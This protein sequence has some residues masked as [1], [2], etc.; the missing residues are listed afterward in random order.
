MKRRVSTNL[1]SKMK[2]LIITVPTGKT[3]LPSSAAPLHSEGVFA[4]SFTWIFLPAGSTNARVLSAESDQSGLFTSYGTAAAVNFVGFFGSMQPV[5]E[6]LGTG[7][8][9]SVGGEQVAVGSG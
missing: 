8:S 7:W 3:H 1:P 6:S 2:F 4:Q 9:R 5:C